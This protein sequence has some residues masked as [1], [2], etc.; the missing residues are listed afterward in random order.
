MFSLSIRVSAGADDTIIS[1]QWAFPIPPLGETLG[2]NLIASRHKFLGLRC[3]RLGAE[4][5]RDNRLPSSLRSLSA[6]ARKGWGG[7]MAVGTAQ[8][9]HTLGTRCLWFR[10]IRS[11][12]ESWL[13][14]SKLDLYIHQGSEML[15][16]GGEGTEL[17]GGATTGVMGHRVMGTVA[18]LFPLQSPLQSSLELSNH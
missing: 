8:G 5:W 16:A 11:R 13:R 6:G 3:A 17:R 7:I 14:S 1:K 12:C 15:L 9:T 2:F 18:A 4:G 10:G